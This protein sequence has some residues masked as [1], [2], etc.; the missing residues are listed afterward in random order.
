L[1]GVGILPKGEGGAH[2]KIIVRGKGGELWEGH[3][4]RGT[5]GLGGKETSFFFAL[6]KGGGCEGHRESSKDKEN[7]FLGGG[8][9]TNG[10]P[11][12]W[13]GGREPSG[14]GGMSTDITGGKRCHT[15]KGTEGNKNWIEVPKG[16]QGTTAKS[17]DGKN[18]NGN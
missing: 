8:G 4:G 16:S 6:R 10:R 15:Q 5:G 3:E 12:L 18:L 13:G 7:P 11:V 14:K 17:K 2:K 9:G 1:V